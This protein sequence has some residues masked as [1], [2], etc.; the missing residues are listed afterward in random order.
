MTGERD[1]KIKFNSH[2]QDAKRRGI[3]F[4]F[5][6]EEWRDWWL[7]DGRWLRRGRGVGNLVMARHGDVGPYSLSN[8]RPATREENMADIPPER[9]TASAIRGHRDRKARGNLLPIEK[10]GAAHP[11]SKAVITPAGPFES[12]ALAADHFGVT[13][14]AIY[15]RIHKGFPGYAFVK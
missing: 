13:K 14:E 2:K 15:Y 4:L 7:A 9:R 6:F 5:S 3:P 8:V 1:M 11:Q 12:G 10:R